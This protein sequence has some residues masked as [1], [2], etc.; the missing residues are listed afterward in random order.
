MKANL[1]L[2]LGGACLLA[3]LLTML[4]LHFSLVQDW[5]R[6]QALAGR[7][8]VVQARVLEFLSAPGP[9]SLIPQRSVRFQLP[10]PLGL[11]GTLPISAEAARQSEQT[12]RVAV[13]YLPDQPGVQALEGTGAPLTLGALLLGLDLFAGWVAWQVWASGRRARHRKLGHSKEGVRQ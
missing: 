13:R 6:T 11:T 2:W 9:R 4:W 5:R 8:V 7:G 3:L 1:A 12:R 10:A